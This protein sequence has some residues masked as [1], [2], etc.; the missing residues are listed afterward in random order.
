M[1]QLLSSERKKYSES[2]FLEIYTL[3]KVYVQFYLTKNLGR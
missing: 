2:S 1:S 3:G